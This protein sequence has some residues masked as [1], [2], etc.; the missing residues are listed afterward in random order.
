MD[1][2][3]VDGMVCLM[4]AECKDDHALSGVMKL[5]I[6][7]MHEPLLTYDLYSDFVALS[8]SS[9]TFFHLVDHFIGK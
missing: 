9:F 6:R 3:D 2:D 4:T 5:A 7:E 8:N 1:A